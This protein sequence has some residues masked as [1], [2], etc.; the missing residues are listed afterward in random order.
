M[1]IRKSKIVSK[2]GNRKRISISEYLYDFLFSLNDFR[3]S[4]YILP[5]G[6]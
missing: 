6:Y 1:V 5:N 2:T 4:K 3:I